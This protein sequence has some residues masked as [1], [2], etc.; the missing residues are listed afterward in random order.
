M[1][2]MK[3]SLLLIALFSVAFA[4]QA[5]AQMQVKKFGI[6]LGQDWDMLPGLSK[7]TLLAKT[8]GSISDELAPFFNLSNSSQYSS[9]CDNPNVRLSLVLQPQR[10]SNVELHTSGVFIFN[11]IDAVHLYDSDDDGYSHLSFSL[12]GNEI[13]TETVLLRKVP[14]LGFANLKFLNLYGGVGANMGYQFGNRISAYAHD[15]R[16]EQTSGQ[17]PRGAFMDVVDRSSYV[18][19]YGNIGDGISTRVFAQAGFGIT[20]FR[21]VELGLEARYGAGLRHY[22]GTDTDFTNLHSVAFNMRYVLNNGQ[23]KAERAIK[24]AERAERAVKRT[25]RMRC[26]WEK[27]KNCRNW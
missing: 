16:Y 10:W 23:S 18:Y 19:D 7:E 9:A 5:D 13:G 4:F 21:R 27:Y 24:R 20:F 14:V 26:T 8:D 12:Y 25:E 22:F 11:R 6:S 1:S 2:F 3:K 17:T 15:V